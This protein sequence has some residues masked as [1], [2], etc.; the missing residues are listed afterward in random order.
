MVA[1][2]LSRGRHR[3]VGHTCRKRRIRHRSGRSLGPSMPPRGDWRGPQS[4]GR[5]RILRTGNGTGG[6]RSGSGVFTY[7]QLNEPVSYNLAAILTG[8]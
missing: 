4:P 8:G 1:L 5:S 7:D 6:A 3:G 2:T